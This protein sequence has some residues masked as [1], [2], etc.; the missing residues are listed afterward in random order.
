MS[1]YIQASEPF[2]SDR[3]DFSPHIDR[4]V[5]P[6]DIQEKM[7][8]GGDNENNVLQMH[9]VTHEQFAKLSED[10]GSLKKL[11]MILVVSNIILIFVCS[12]SVVYQE[13]EYASKTVDLVSNSVTSVDEVK[14]IIQ[15]NL[16]LN[17]SL[18]NVQKH[19]FCAL[20]DTMRD[21]E[22]YF[23]ESNRNNECCIGNISNLIRLLH[24]TFLKNLNEYNSKVAG[25]ETSI[26]DVKED[27]DIL[28]TS[29][30]SSNKINSTDRAS[31]G[32]PKESTMWAKIQKNNRLINA[33]LNRRRSVLHLSGT[34]D[35]TRI[36]WT[37]EVQ[38][39]D[40]SHDEQGIHVRSGGKY[41][42]YSNI[43]FSK[44]VCDG[45]ENF[46]YRIDQ[47]YSGRE[48]IPIARV[49]KVCATGSSIDTGLLV[50]SVLQVG[51]GQ[52]GTFRIQ[53]DRNNQ[54][55]IAKGNKLHSIIVFEI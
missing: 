52:H 50:Q 41:F 9:D 28:Q 48:F 18:I 47:I 53:Y 13:S 51:L 7:I 30:F 44:N 14:T 26:E 22:P 38:S 19:I 43:H 55:F 34:A 40:L 6:A 23:F 16:E 1:G 4:D 37:E 10:F 46:G 35:T 32:I 54:E 17:D 15:E 42:I 33:M 25:L 27:I 24:H 20:C 45:T 3:K 8:Q 11:I 21:V 39:G 31:D 12:V 29:L 36:R 2:L 5:R 49:E